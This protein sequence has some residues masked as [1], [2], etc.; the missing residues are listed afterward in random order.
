M[1]TRY[2]RRRAPPRTA[3]SVN[4]S[5]ELSF[6]RPLVTGASG[7]IGRAL[8]RRL[9][10]ADVPVWCSARHA[11]ATQIDGES[12]FV[13]DLADPAFVDAS[14]R[15]P[16]RCGVPSRQRGHRRTRDREGGADASEQPDR[17]REHA[18]SRDRGACERIVLIG[19][20]DEPRVTQRHARRTRPR[21]GPP[22]IR[23]D[24]PLPLRHASDDRPAVHGVRARTNRTPRR[25]C[26][27]SSHRFS[28]AT[29]PAL[30][31]GRRLCDWVYIDDVVEALLA[32]VGAPACIG[33]M[34]DVG[35]GTL[36]TV[37][38][39]VE[40]ICTL[41]GT[42]VAPRWGEHTDRPGETEALA[43]VE[44]TRRLCGWTPS[45]DLATGLRHTAEWYAGS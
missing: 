40:M 33:R 2:I 29:P 1:A 36:H 22:G 26:R 41:M 43:D 31:S 3:N 17:E 38:H 18:R 6:D 34:V 27:T 39:V 42:D 14:S 44:E 8:V 24:V 11:P 10:G 16:P 32:V 4:S 30:T 25:S 45:T 13:G 19:S 37:R 28:E 20:G 5:S 12:W 9:L 21:N 35:T 23:L 15:S 7:F